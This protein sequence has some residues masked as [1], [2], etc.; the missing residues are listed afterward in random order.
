MMNFADAHAIPCQFSADVALSL[1][2]AAAYSNGSF[3]LEH[4]TAQL[5]WQH[6]TTGW[7]GYGS[8]QPGGAR[9]DLISSSQL[10]VWDVWRFCG[11]VST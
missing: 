2:L 7:L 9:P 11:K 5:A 4:E 6:M 3:S 1:R 8:Q 10:M